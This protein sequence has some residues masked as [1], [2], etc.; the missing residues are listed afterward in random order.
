[1][2]D[3]IKETHHCPSPCSNKWWIPPAGPCYFRYKQAATIPTTTGS[4][5][6]N[7]FLELMLYSHT[8]WLI[9]RFILTSCTVKETTELTTMYNYLLINTSLPQNI[10]RKNTRA[11]T[12]QGERGDIH[13]WEGESKRAKLTYWNLWPG[14]Q[15]NSCHSKAG[16]SPFLASVF[17]TGIFI[18]SVMK[19]LYYK[20]SHGVVEELAYLKFKSYTACLSTSTVFSDSS[21]KTAYHW[22]LKYSTHLYI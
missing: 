13:T 8:E 18:I 19:K 1:M 10:H 2:P 21:K 22:V 16:I 6:W 5:A 15:W 12:R 4:H 7:G 14:I 20:L 3:P 17:F 11:K 9:T